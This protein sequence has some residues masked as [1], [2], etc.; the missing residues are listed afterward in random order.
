MSGLFAYS[1][2]PVLAVSLLLFFTAALRG[3]NALGLTLYCLSVAIWS[4]T[5]LLASLPA[6]AAFGTR[7]LAVGAFVAAGF[8]HTA[9]DLT[10]Q[11][12]YALVVLA[13]SV[14]AIITFTGAIRPGVLYTTTSLAPGPLFWPAMVLAV[15]A[16]TIPVAQLFL[17][18][19]TAPI[20]R[21]GLLRRLLVAGLLADVG[22]M[23][24]ALLLSHGIAVP[25]PMLLVL[26]S[27][28]VLADVVRAHEAADEARVLERSLLYAALAAFLSAGFMFGVLSF[29]PE[30]LAGSYKLGAFFLLSMAALAFEPLRQHLGELIG[31]K[32]TRRP[33][34]AALAKALT[35][36]EEKAERAE[37][38]AEIGTLVSAVAHEVRNPLGVLQAQLALLE[39]TGADKEA[40]D[41]MRAQ[42]DRASRFVDDLLRFGRP[43]PLELRKVDLRATVELGFS[44]AKQGLGDAA[45]PSLELEH[46]KLDPGEA[47]AEI[48][49]EADQAQLLQLL[50]IIFENALLAGGARIAATTTGGGGSATVVIEDAGPGISPEIAPRLFQPFV[51]GRKREGPRPG[52]GL[53]LATARRIVERHGGTIRA[54]KSETLGGARFEI[55]LPSIA[56]PAVEELRT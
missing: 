49:V 43:R 55:V 52:T 44:T 53:G 42:I 26:G 48:E 23:S 1:L 3:R 46:R 38:L 35:V 22:G 34:S 51:T 10:K 36:Q 13:Y 39:K 6:T 47:E 28:L 19:R 29:V 20:D 50:V 56:R 9:Y 15:G 54:G 5:L 45:P 17:A 33:H 24:N 14:A 11:R 12:S 32:L 41:G 7:L 16:A 31:G 27:L 21:R 4:G 25:F 8:I 18:Y 37:R 2:V 30:P 40:I